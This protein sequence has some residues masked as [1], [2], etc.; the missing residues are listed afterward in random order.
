MAV[1]VVFLVILVAVIYV[2]SRRK[3]QHREELRGQL[4]RVPE[5]LERRT[6]R[7]GSV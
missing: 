1:V 5:R 6:I 3:T 7:P 2:V 4:H